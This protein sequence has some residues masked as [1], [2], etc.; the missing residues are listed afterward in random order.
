[1]FNFYCNSYKSFLE[2]WQGISRVDFQHLPQK[3]LLR[4]YLNI[5][6]NNDFLTIFIDIKIKLIH[7]NK[8]Q[9]FIVARSQ[10]PTLSGDGSPE[11]LGLTFSDQRANFALASPKAHR[12]DL[13]L[14]VAEAA[15]P[16]VEIPMRG[17]TDGVWHVSVE[18]L[19][20]NGSYAYRIDGGVF[21][22][23]PYARSFSGSCHW[24]DFAC[25]RN[26]YLCDIAPP[27]PFDWQGVDNPR[28][29]LEDLIIYEMHVRGFTMHPSSQVQSKGTY[30]GLIEKIEY[31]KQLGINAVE[32]MPVYEFDETHS[33]KVYSS[34]QLP[35][36]NYWGYNPIS[37]FI[38]VSR[39]ASHP[40]KAIDEFKT[41]VRE[42]HRANIEV[43]LDVVYNHTGEGDDYPVSFRG[44]DSAGY[45]IKD[46]HGADTNY[47]GCGNTFLTNGPLGQ[48]IIIDSL[49]YWTQEMKVDGFRFDLAS[50]LTRDSF[51]H[52][53]ADPPIL[54]AMNQ[55]PVLKNV[56]LIAEPWDAAGLSQVGQFHKW[57][58]WSEWNGSYRDHVRRFIK[59]TDHETGGFA[60]SICGSEPTYPTTNPQSSINFITAHDGF[61]LR[62]LVTYQHKHNI[63]NGENNRDGADHNENWNCGAE[64]P[65][66]NREIHE[67][68]ERQLRNFWLALFLSQG[69]PMFLMG[70]EYG[71]TRKGNNNPYVQ[72]NDINWFDW[73]VLKHNHSMQEFVTSLIR[74]RKSHP[75]FRKKWFL[76]DEDIE[77]HGHLPHRP[78]WKTHSRFIAFTLKSDTPIYAAFNADVRE[79]LV[80][81]PPANKWRLIV[82]TADC[83]DRHHLNEPQKGFPLNESIELLPFSAI[84]AIGAN[85]S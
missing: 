63:E 85:H 76:E 70:D 54:K 74:F 7:I 15:T 49:R 32:L 56:K 71:H 44:I 24:G 30:T 21:L 69:I 73:D 31:L 52:P 33:P 2:S 10:T 9:A 79:A 51:G 11:P 43:I 5:S 17:P 39:Y 60:A 45:F 6:T 57:G 48:K 3:S 12:V 8:K 50:I 80:Y 13:C 72:D 41:M 83:W 59:G 64:G 35:R 34:T 37:F 77:W 67:L 53:M 16:I 47:T 42:L 28:I 62:D 38:P 20:P 1:M 55:D 36:I 22:A 27:T 78:D 25:R 18:A 29:P 84:V 4:L 65:T 58:S 81:L 66:Q 46:K 23:D 75:V 26:P 68:R 40:Q 19:P 14:F 61:C 82:N